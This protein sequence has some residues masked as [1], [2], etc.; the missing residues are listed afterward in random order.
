MKKTYV[1]VKKLSD[2]TNDDYV[3]GTPADRLGLMW[4]RRLAYSPLS[5]S[6]SLDT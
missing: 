1:T 2:R 5:L 6:Q 4:P 3:P